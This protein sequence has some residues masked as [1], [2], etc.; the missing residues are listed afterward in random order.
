MNVMGRLCLGLWKALMELL[1][2]S[3]MLRLLRRR[4]GDYVE[5][6]RDLFR[7]LTLDEVIARA[8]EKSERR[9]P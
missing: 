3:A 8:R 5:E 9:E 2:F 7:D 4:R 6:R 1:G